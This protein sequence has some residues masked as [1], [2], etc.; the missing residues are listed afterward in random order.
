M[1][2]TTTASRTPASIR[3]GTAQPTGAVA[4]AG[5]ALTIAWIHVLDQGGLLALKEP[6]YLGWGYRSLV[7]AAVVC[8]G[9]LLLGRYRFGWLLAVAVS[10]GPLIGIVVSRSVGLPHATDDI[11]NW[12]EPLGVAAWSSRLRCSWSP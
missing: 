6:A 12:G 10:A 2:S 5:L 11:G 7:V 1:T 4:A 3:S 8:A 9:L